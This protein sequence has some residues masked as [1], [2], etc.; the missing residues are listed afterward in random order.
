MPDQELR[1]LLV[2]DSDLDAELCEQE[3]REAGLRFEARRVCTRDM[4]ERSLAEHPPDVI[5]CDFSMPTDLDGMSALTI[6]RERIPDI[7]FVFVSGTIGEERAVEAMK[8]GATDYVLKDKLQRLAPVVRRALR[9]A[10]ERQAKAEAEAALRASEIARKA[11]DSANRAK[12][13]FLAV[14]SHEIRTPMNGMLGML[15]LLGRSALGAE[16]R[17]MVDVSLESGKALQRIID[18]IL[19]FS[20]IEA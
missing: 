12:S 3:L 6:A 16:Q 5:L 1:I 7:P 14:M 17:N 20:K 15:E 9:E 4:L 13:A 8:A 18:D 11:A 2:E 19:D 10:A